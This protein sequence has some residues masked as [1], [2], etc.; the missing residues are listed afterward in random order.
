MLRPRKLRKVR[1]SCRFIDIK[2]YEDLQSPSSLL[3]KSLEIKTLSKLQTRT[4]QSRLRQS[5]TINTLQAIE[6]DVRHRQYYIYAYLLGLAQRRPLDE[7]CL[8]IS[9]HCTLKAGN[10]YGLD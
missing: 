1:S 6:S 10:Y 3:D 8:N 9:T 5:Y 2:V 7:A 4:V